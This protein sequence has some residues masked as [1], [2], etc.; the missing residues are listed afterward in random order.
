ML[1][2]GRALMGE[3]KLLMLDEPSLGL[4]PQIVARFSR[5]SADQPARRAHPARG[6][7]RAA[8]ARIAHRGYVIV[9]GENSAHRHRR[10]APRQRRGA[11]GLSWG[12]NFANGAAV[13][14]RRTQSP[15]QEVNQCDGHTPPLHFQGQPSRK[16]GNLGAQ[17]V[18]R[19]FAL[20]TR[21]LVVPRLRWVHRAMRR[22]RHSQEFA[23]P[24]VVIAENDRRIVARVEDF[25]RRPRRSDAPAPR[26]DRTMNLVDPARA[27]ALDHRF[28]PP[29]FLEERASIRP[30]N[31][32][33]ANDRRTARERLFGLAAKSGSSPRPAPPATSS[34]HAP[35]VWP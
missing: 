4:A 29:E 30:V 17:P 1:A 34:T 9:T 24:G 25:T 7:K 6:T 33:R 32:R 12:V 35:S 11:A 8:G 26:P 13:S 23:A 10:G 20:E 28:A 3:P 22:H 21:L 31:S 2:I 5:S 19:S 14:D 15:R 16:L 18:A 27:V